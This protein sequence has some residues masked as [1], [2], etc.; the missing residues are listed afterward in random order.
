MGVRWKV[1]D[2]R[3]IRF[4]EDTWVGTCCLATQF[5]DLYILAEQKNVS[6][7]SV[8]D[9]RTLKISFRRRV[10][11]RLIRLWEELVSLVELVNFET[12]CD[13]IIW[14]FQGNGQFAV[15]P[16]YKAVSFRGIQPVHT[17]VVWQL[18]VPPRIH[19]FLWLMANNKTLTRSNLVKRQNLDDLSCLFCA[20]SETVHH[21]FFECYVPTTMWLILSEIFG[22]NLGTDF[23][24]V[25]RWWISNK[26]C[27]HEHLL[28]CIDVVH[29]ENA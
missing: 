15:H 24:S 8:W 11:P 14:T 18:N 17:P 7:A 9:G 4:W 12:D 3:T 19:I 29:L 27:Y 23:E 16:M 13:S 25:A 1:G 6:L 5:W 2:G 26:K 21:L 20:E 28:R 22:R 10:E